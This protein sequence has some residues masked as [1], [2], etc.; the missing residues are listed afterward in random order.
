MTSCHR[1]PNDHNDR[2]MTADRRDPK[3]GHEH[4]SDRL[5]RPSR[6]FWFRAYAICNHHRAPFPCFKYCKRTMAV[7]CVSSLALCLSAWTVSS[8]HVD[9]PSRRYHGGAPRNHA[10]QLH[11][12]CS[13]PPHTRLFASLPEESQSSPLI[14]LQT[15]LKLC[16][17]VQT[18][19]EAKALIQGSEC[20]L[21]GKVETRRAKK[22]FPGDLVSFGQVTLDVSDEV[23]SRGYV[24]KAKRKKVKPQPMV[25]AEGNL[26]FG[27]R[28]RSEEWR[29]ERK[30]KK[31]KHKEKNSKKE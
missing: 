1:E 26:E 30:L 23:A 13:P 3:K 24:Y 19:G 10:N 2:T 8:F 4:T 16:G 20:F 31:A 29:A 17:L 28:Y 7:K 25:D 27:G 14:D 9:L 5:F 6:I 12:T 11:H 15:F 18:G 21:N 22:L